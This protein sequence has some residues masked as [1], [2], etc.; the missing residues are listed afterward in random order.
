[1]SMIRHR[2]CRSKSAT[3]LRRRDSEVSESDTTA[4]RRAT[5]ESRNRQIQT[6]NNTSTYC[7]DLARADRLRLRDAEV[8]T[9]LASQKLV[10]FSVSWNGRR[11]V[12]VGIEVHAVLTTFAQ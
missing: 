6:A 10:D 3:T 11:L 1:M 7:P 2:N 4:E 5:I 8:P 9:N 12:V